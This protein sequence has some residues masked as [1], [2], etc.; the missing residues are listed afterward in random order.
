MKTTRLMR[1]S[2]SVGPD[3]PRFDPHVFVN[4]PR[5]LMLV[6]SFT[7]TIPSRMVEFSTI[8]RVS[9]RFLCTPSPQDA[10]CSE[11]FSSTSA[12][13]NYDRLRRR[14]LIIRFSSENNCF[15]FC[16]CF[17]NV[18]ARLSPARKSRAGRG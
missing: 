6:F 8:L 11:P 12:L 14:T 1:S 18:R 3:S 17:L 15:R 2:L 16:G 7:S 4:V 9:A 10:F 5:G 13:A